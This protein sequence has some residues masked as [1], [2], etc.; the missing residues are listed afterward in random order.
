MAEYD[1]SV[2]AE[3]VSLGRE[4]VGILYITE[5]FSAGILLVVGSGYYS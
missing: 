4:G 1:W 3:V 2:G 5:A